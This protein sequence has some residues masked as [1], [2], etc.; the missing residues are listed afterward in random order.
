MSLIYTEALLH[1]TSSPHFLRGIQYLV[2]Q[3]GP[4]GHVNCKRTIMAPRVQKVLF[5][6][7]NMTRFGNVATSMCNQSS[8]FY[9]VDC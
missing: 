1:L 9:Q 6:I 5:S 2:I 7:P 4:A 3:L 8:I